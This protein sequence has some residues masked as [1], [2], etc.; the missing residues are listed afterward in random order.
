MKTEN[1]EHLQWIHDRL[2]N[3]HGENENVDYL[4]RLRKIIEERKSLERTFRLSE[5]NIDRMRAVEKLE[6]CWACGGLGWR[7]KGDPIRQWICETCK[8]TGKKD[9]KAKELIGTKHRER[10]QWEY[11]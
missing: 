1:S 3:V 6:D 2:I 9:W 7:L 8:G 4:I 11:H 5:A 10:T